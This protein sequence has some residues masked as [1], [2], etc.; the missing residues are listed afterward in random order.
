MTYEGDLSYHAAASQRIGERVGHDLAV[1]FRH[2]ISSIR[3][4]IQGYAAIC[5]GDDGYSFGCDNPVMAENVVSAIQA[6]ADEFVLKPA[7][8][9]ARTLCELCFIDGLEQG[10]GKDH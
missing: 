3:D 6:V 4:A 2:E 1:H 7:P 8:A 10:A 9:E 5:R